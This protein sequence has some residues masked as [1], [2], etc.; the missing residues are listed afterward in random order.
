MVFSTI[1]TYPKT[2]YTIHWDAYKHMRYSY[3][4]VQVCMKLPLNCIRD[5]IWWLEQLSFF[6]MLFVIQMIIAI[7]IFII[8]LI[9][10][11]SNNPIWNGNE[12]TTFMW[13]CTIHLIWIVCF[14]CNTKYVF[15]HS[16][17]IPINYFLRAQ[18]VLFCLFFFF[19]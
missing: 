9:V 8:G 16:A 6:L 3:T 2:L 7:V 10:H 13:R 14:D 15:I 19:T 11:R 4:L 1:H 17:L 12:D 5:R 18:K